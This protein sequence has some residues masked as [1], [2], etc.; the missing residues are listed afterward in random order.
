MRWPERFRHERGPVFQYSPRIRPR[1]VERVARRRV[2]RP[3]KSTWRTFSVT[4]GTAGCP[5]CP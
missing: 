3:W 2:K 1:G 4:V 5:R